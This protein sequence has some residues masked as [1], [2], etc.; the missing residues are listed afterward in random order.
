MVNFNILTLELTLIVAILKV[1]VFHQIFNY[2]KK[3]CKKILSCYPKKLIKV[4]Y[5][6]GILLIKDNITSLFAIDAFKGH[7]YSSLKH[8]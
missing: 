6:G 3:I 4:L 7:D 1:D 5:V 2:N 8:V